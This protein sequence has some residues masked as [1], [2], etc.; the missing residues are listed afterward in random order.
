MV[1]C[2][3]TQR[4]I[5]RTS[6]CL[7]LSQAP[8]GK[9]TSGFSHANLLG[10]APGLS[11]SLPGLSPNVAR[12]DGLWTKALSS[13]WSEQSFACCEGSQF[14]RLTFVIHCFLR[15]LSFGK[16]KKLTFTPLKLLLLHPKAAQCT[17]LLPSQTPRVKCDVIS[18]YFRWN[19]ERFTTGRHFVISVPTRYKAQYSRIFQDTTKRRISKMVFPYT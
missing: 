11:R 13:K 9:W 1:T 17:M 2:L 19:D 12:N 15:Y 7:R 18:E 14:F 3:G 4:S 10:T 5:V 6:C 16:P 8:R